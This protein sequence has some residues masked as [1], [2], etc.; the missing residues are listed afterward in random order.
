[1]YKLKHG[2]LQ[3]QISRINKKFFETAKSKVITLLFKAI[4]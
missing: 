4:N 1:M 3:K 2:V